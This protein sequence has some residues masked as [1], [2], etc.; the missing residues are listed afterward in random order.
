M[1]DDV[2]DHAVVA[3][4]LLE[5]AYR[6]REGDYEA[7]QAILVRTFTLLHGDPSTMPMR[8]QQSGVPPAVCGGLAAWQKRRV[9]AY[10]NTHIAAR[11]RIEDLAR[12]LDLSESH[13]SRAFRRAFGISP[14]DYLARRRI[15]LAQSLM[16][17][18][19]ERLCAIALHCGL[20]DQSHFTTLFRRIVGETPYAWRRSRQGEIE[21]LRNERL[22]API[23]LRSNV[24]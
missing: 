2:N 5:A 19:D 23:G 7:A 14:H 12:L 8:S 9:V 16:L 20:C 1:V 6:A 11:I 15:E 18:T 22:I 17:T 3:T 10:I 13:F 21:G 24:A 4:Q